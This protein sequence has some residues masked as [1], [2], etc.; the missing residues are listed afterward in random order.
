MD[1]VAAMGCCV[2]GGA[3]TIHHVTA[4]VEG[5]RISR[6]HRL[7][8]P[9]CPRHH[10]IIFGPRESVEAL[11]HRGFFAEYGIDLLALAEMLWASS[12]RSEA[13]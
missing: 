6:S 4:K 12:E 3:A 7:V 9:L 8:A 13:A 1:R 11:S 2:C 10:Q 5:G